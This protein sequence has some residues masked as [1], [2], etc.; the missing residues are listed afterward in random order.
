MIPLFMQIINTNKHIY[1]PNNIW[2]SANRAII[3]PTLRC[4]TREHRKP[5]YI[6]KESQLKHGTKNRLFS[7]IACIALS[8][9]THYSFASDITKCPDIAAMRMEGISE[10]TQSWK[11][12]Y[13]AHISNY[14]TQVTWKL[15]ICDGFKGGGRPTAAEAIEWG[16]KVLQG[17]S[18][19]PTPV[20]VTCKRYDKCIAE[21]KYQVQWDILIA[22]TADYF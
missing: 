18:G 6:N 21:C 20:F 12:W 4:L 9:S 17:A 19:E 7:A 15:D 2:K 22:K 16:N 1:T 3:L 8:L 5:L 13:P 10:A 14:D 11:S